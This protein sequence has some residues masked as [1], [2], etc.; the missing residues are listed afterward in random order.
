[1]CLAILIEHLVMGGW[2]QDH[3]VYPSIASHGKNVV[4]SFYTLWLPLSLIS[5]FVYLLAVT[6]SCYV[7][8]V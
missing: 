3:S 4:R 8:R 2:T 1:M 6:L 7:V 5:F